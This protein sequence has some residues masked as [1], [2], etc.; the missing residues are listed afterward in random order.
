MKGRCYNPNDS[1]YVNYGARGIHLTIHLIFEYLS[2][3]NH[4]ARGIQI[5]DE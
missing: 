1:S 2:Y 5:S 3:V 4:G